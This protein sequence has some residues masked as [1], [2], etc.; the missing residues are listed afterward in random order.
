LGDLLLSVL[1]NMEAQKFFRKGIMMKMKF[2]LTA[3]AIVALATVSASAGI[4]GELGI[5]DSSA[6]GGINPVTGAAWAVGDTYRLAFTT[7]GVTDATS[8]DI[9]TYNTFV[10][11]AADAA[12]LGTGWNVIGSTLDMDAKDNTGTNVGDGVATFLMDGVTKAF[13]NNADMWDGRIESSYYHDGEARDHWGIFLDENGEMR[14]AEVFTGTQNS[15]VVDAARPLGNTNPEDL[16]ITLGHSD[17]FR[18]DRWI[19]RWNAPPTAELPVFGLSEVLTVVPEPATM[20]LLGLGGLVLRR[21]R[22]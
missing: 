8:T 14:S 7:S 18:N 4:I 6:N 13:D 19:L 2:L 16:K 5:L 20:I 12:G 3:M 10:Q 9:A 21:R 1:L 17:F 22:A 11:D 15:G